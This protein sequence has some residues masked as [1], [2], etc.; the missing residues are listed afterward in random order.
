MV[1]RIAGEG[2]GGGIFAPCLHPPRRHGEG[3]FAPPFLSCRRPPIARAE[4][5]IAIFTPKSLNKRE[6]RDLRQ[7]VKPSPA[8][9]SF[10]ERYDLKVTR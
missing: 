1:Q 2:K 6:I 7:K 3:H 5:K 4:V 9:R 8:K 10:S